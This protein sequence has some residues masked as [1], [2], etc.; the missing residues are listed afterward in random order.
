MMQKVAIVTDSIACLPRELV[1]QYGIGIVPLNF[2]FGD[3]VY[4]DWVDITPTQAYELFLKD[5]ESFKTSPASPSVYFEAYR[6]ASDQTKNI[7]CI[8]LSSK[9][10][11]GYDMACVA[12]ERA[13]TEFPQT[14]IEVLDSQTVTAAEGFVALAAARA[15]E[16]GKSLAEVVEAAKEMRDRVTF[17]A[18]LDTIRHIYRTGRIPKIAAQ[19]GSMLNI[20]PILTSSSGL[21]RFIGAVRSR[22]RG[23]ERLLKIMRDKVEQ[24]PVHVAVMHAYARDEG[25]KLK[26]RISS[27]FNCAELWITEFS[28]VMGYA[29]GTGTLALA[30]YKE[31]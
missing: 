29:T 18:L 31:G 22:E 14:F 15:A 28:P 8:T 13:K 24:S 12:K 11:T 3:K 1:E 2:Y 16:E 21:I 19:A 5:P 4:K 23:I 6:E 26:E 30:F 25:E 7:L 20:K 10:S 27:E 17:L 9:L